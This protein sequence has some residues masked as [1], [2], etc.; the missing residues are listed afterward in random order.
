MDVKILN[1]HSK[2]M[3]WVIL[4]MGFGLSVYLRDASAFIACCTVAGGL[5]ANKTYQARKE[6]YL[7]TLESGRYHERQDF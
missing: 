7:R 2:A 3:G 4:F 5:V 6:K 1:S